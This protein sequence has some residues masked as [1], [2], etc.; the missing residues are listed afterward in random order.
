MPFSGAEVFDFETE[1]FN[2]FFYGMWLQYQFA[3]CM[4]WYIPIIC[5]FRGGGRLGQGDHRFQANVGDGEQPYV[6]N[7]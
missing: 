7:K 5:F 4:W 3:S 2:V 1:L 6:K